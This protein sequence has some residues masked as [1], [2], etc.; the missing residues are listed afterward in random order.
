ME[1]QDAIVDRLKQ[2]IIEADFEGAPKITE[3][4]LKAGIQADVLMH[5]GVSDGLSELEQKLF[6]GYKTW[7]HPLLFMGAEA[8][9]RSLELLEPYFKPNEENAIGTVV[10]GTPSGDVHDLG[11]KMVA[12]ALIAAGFKVVYLGRDVAPSLFVHKVKEHGAD[13]LAISSYQTTGFSRIE[14]I[15][16]LLSAAG[17]KDKVKVMVGGPCIT[18]KFAD[19]KGLGYGAHA[20]DA[21]KLAKEYMGR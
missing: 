19:S 6:N 9:R 4:A 13:I 3:E 18:P 1:K 11:G 12:L 21:A 2:A 8:A 16:S 7:G 15:L 10:M 20:S 5:R 14:E 17:L